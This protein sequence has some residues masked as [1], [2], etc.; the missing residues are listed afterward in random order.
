MPRV[1]AANAPPVRASLPA[2]PRP[3]AAAHEQ[4]QEDPPG[5][6]DETDPGSAQ[7]TAEDPDARDAALREGLAPWFPEATLS[8]DLD[9]VTAL[10]EDRERL[11]K[12]V[13]DA[14]FLSRA[15]KR[16]MLGLPEEEESQ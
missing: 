7:P 9:R 10:S 1:H 12:Q 3:R 5:M 2:D 16:R 15:E 14:E 11:W 4:K 8:I 6:A 13:S